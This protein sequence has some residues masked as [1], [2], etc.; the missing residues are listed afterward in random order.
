MTGTGRALQADLARQASDIIQ[1][2]EQATHAPTT[3]MMQQIVSF[4]L[5]LFTA[6]DSD[7]DA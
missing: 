4:E 6:Q 3:E 7:A 5:G 2:T 1:G